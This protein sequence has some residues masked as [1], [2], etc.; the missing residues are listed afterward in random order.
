MICSALAAFAVAAPA[1]AQDDSTEVEELVITG[2]R[3][4]RPN[5]EAPTAV[6]VI[7]Q[8]IIEATGE[9]NTGDI[10][11]TLPQTGVS[12]LTPTNSNFFTTDNGVTT[13]DLRNLG[14]DRT[15]VLMNGRR[16]VAGLP[17]SQIVD[18][19]SIPTEFVER[20]DVVT[21]GASA[22]YGSDALAGVINIITQRDFEGFE[23]F[24]QAG[25]TEYGDYENQR[26][27]IKAGANFADGRGN[28]AGLLSFSNQGAVFARDRCDRDM[29]VDGL[30]GGF[31]GE[32]FR[33][34]FT[35]FFSSFIPRGVA[36]VP[37]IGAGNLT[38]VVDDSGA[39]VPYVG[40][41]FGFNRQARRA[42]Y[43]PQQAI[44][45][46]MMMDYEINEAANFF[47]EFTLYHG[48]TAN[49]IEPTPLGS[50][51]IFRDP[52]T[53]APQSPS[54]R[55]FDADGDIECRYGIPIT[56]AIVPDSLAAAVRAAT[57]GLDDSERVVGY[58]RRLT[59]VGNRHN[60]ADRQLARL[61]FGL[62]GD[63]N[64]T[65]A[66]EVSMNRGRT[67]SSQITQGGI[68]R[69][70]FNQATDAVEL[71]DG[72]IVC[73][74][75]EARARGCEPFFVFEEGRS[76]EAAVDFV[77]VQ[78]Q[79]DAYIEQWV[80]NGFLTGQTAF[81]LPAGPTEWVFGGEYRRE[82]SRLTPDPTLQ[83]GLASGNIAEESRGAFDVYEVFGE[84]R[85][86]LLRDMPLAQSLDLNLAGRFSDY[87]TVNTT[88]AWAASLEY[89][90]VDWL[91]LRAQYAQAVRAP[92]ISEL[93]SG[94][95]QT[96]EVVSDP[97]IGLTLTGGGVPTFFNNPM[98]PTSGID[99]DA[100]DTTT[101]NACYADPDL[102]ARVARDGWFIPTQP[103]LQG[104]GGF[105][106][107]N[108]DLDAE[109][110]ETVTFGIL[111]NPKW[112]PWLEPLSVSIDYFDIEV[113]NAIQQYGRN[114][115]LNRCYGS[116]ITDQLDPF[117]CQ[118]IVRFDATTPNVG[119]LQEVNQKNFN[120][121]TLK[122]SGVDLQASYN[123]AVEN[124][125]YTR[126]GFDWGNLLIS[127]QVQYL[128]DYTTVPLPGGEPN[129]Q[130][131][132][133]GLAEWEGLLKFLYSRGPMQ[134]ALQTQYVGESCFFSTPCEEDDYIDGAYIGH[135]FFTGG[136]VRYDL[137]DI[138][139]VYAGV[140]NMFD[141][142][143]L[144][145]QSQGQPTGWTTEPAIYDGLGRR[146]YAGFRLR[147]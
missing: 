104:T 7:D 92:N 33:A 124:L 31:F 67:T 91:K 111:F 107:G 73:A 2:S 32:D 136:Q 116:S 22:V 81:S 59:E 127:L 95:N 57:P 88:E 54:C 71:P 20:I 83:T 26:I 125:P 134:V 119:A 146:F 144:I 72:T 24:G 3:I 99:A 70:E 106:E 121:A 30:G 58:Q 11:R 68:L 118:S 52:G 128:D 69:R 60:E 63:L 85:I 62:K 110:G 115:T 14:E 147:F 25:I 132:F 48:S 75:P 55:D 10:V 90:P 131:G 41:V 37:R 61:V 142:Y 140:D 17:G 141:E 13:V 27:G 76:S 108:P 117:Y 8:R 40:S 143:V 42:L 96:F 1:Q 28:A 64:P 38:R 47:S 77:S 21:G 19:N 35:P 82:E 84:L 120:I 89:E 16:Y 126:D 129:E 138:T 86:P 102:A 97:C 51:D 137:N 74:D 78:N 113:T 130:K 94:R 109:Q 66:Y 105:N 15:L 56:S 50:T 79:F 5:L 53:N 135:R 36:L 46:A 44:K 65:T 123:L 4:A 6:A 139:R 112:T 18:F 87:S 122:T 39:T 29:C 98:D 114:L 9:I 101:A 133:T 43:V 93:Y 23:V 80:I 12:A 34:T 45:F 49:D 100:T 103:E 145:G